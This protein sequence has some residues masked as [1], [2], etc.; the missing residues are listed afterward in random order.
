MYL[1]HAICKHLKS[2]GTTPD[3]KFKNEVDALSAIRPQSII[4]TNYDE[5][6][7]GIFTDYQPV[8]GKGLITAPFANVG[9]IYKIHGTI[10]KPSS[11]ILTDE[12][13]KRFK[14]QRRYL[15]AKL[16]TFF[17]EHPILFIGYSIED[18][19]IQG[20]L[21]DL[22]DAMD[23]PGSV[24]ENVFWLSRS[25]PRTAATEKVVQVSPSKGVRIN[26]I[27]TDDFSWVFNAFGHNTP[28]ENV[29][30][31]VL[32][33]ILARSYHLVRTD[34]P[35]Q[36]VEVDFGFISDRTSSEK[37]FAKLFGIADLETATEFSA[38][39]CFNLTGVGKKLGY[40]NWHKANQLLEMIKKTHNIDLKAS[41]NR[42]HCKVKTGNN[43]EAHMYST[44]AVD[45]LRLVRDKK[46]Y[47]IDL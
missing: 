8:L 11:I 44:D 23:I 25:A 10:A 18:Q 34:I 33:A 27:E 32:R 43:S 15:T 20:V 41:D 19:N 9:E 26:S 40:K 45:L 36:T 13:Y 42:Y 29:N 12:D 1:K 30:Q 17:A 16:L 4:T 31:K 14:K 6:L 35:R 47:T 38:K 37:E 2:Y 24:V 22:D 7:E 28:L 5:L 3:P 21:S 39:Y 46:P